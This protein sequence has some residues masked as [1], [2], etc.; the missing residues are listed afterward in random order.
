MNLSTDYLGL[1]LSN[2]FVVGSSPFGDKT[3]VARQIQD[4][5]AAAIVMRSCSRNRSTPSS[6]RCCCTS[7]EPPRA[8]PGGVLLPRLRRLPLRRTI[9]S[10]ACELKRRDIRSLLTL[11]ARRVLDDYARRFEAGARTRSREPLSAR[12]DPTRPRRDEPNARVVRSVALRS[13]SDLGQTLPFQ[14]RPRNSP[15]HRG[16]GAGRVLINVSTSDFTLEIRGEA[17]AAALGS[18]RALLRWAGGDHLAHLAARCGEGASL[19]R[20]VVKALPRRRDAVQVVSCC[21]A[22]APVHSRSS[23]RAE[24]ARRSRLREARNCAAR[25]PAALPDPARRSSARITSASCQAGGVGTEEWELKLSVEGRTR[26]LD[27]LHLS[28]LNLGSNSSP[29]PHEYPTAWRANPNTPGARSRG[30]LPNAPP[31]SAPALLRVY[32]NPDRTWW[33]ARRALYPVSQCAVHA[34]LPAANRS[35]VARAGGEA[36]FSRCGGVARHE[37]P[38]RICSRLPA[39]RLCEARA[40]LKRSHPV[41]IRRRDDSSTTTRSRTVD[42]SRARDAKRPARGI[43]GSGPAARLRR[44]A[45][46]A[47]LRRDGVRIALVPGAC[48]ER[49]PAFKLAK[50]LIE[51]RIDLLGAA[52][53]ESSVGVEIGRDPHARHAAA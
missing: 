53:R 12:P 44:R 34:G 16:G 19:H 28:T 35:G 6:A 37:Q 38:A 30:S 3:Y 26:A 49:H 15:P 50:P 1:K 7:R 9:T 13:D 20:G 17:A 27:P 21:C 43:V 48:S 32:D 41:A 18:E 5:G 25:S 8:P 31:T 47:R 36:G 14:P 24:L 11:N 2:P 33:R 23:R 46:A 45:G 4:A 51:R 10:P 29:I 52:R 22:T 39:G 40:C 42:R